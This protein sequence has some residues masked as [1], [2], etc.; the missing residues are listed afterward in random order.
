MDA[1]NTR[2]K[3]KTAPANSTLAA[4]LKRFLARVPQDVEGLVEI[5]RAAETSNLIDGDVL[6]MMEGALAVSQ[7]RVHEII[8]PRVHMVSVKCN[9]RLQQIL[10]T[11]TES[12]HSRFP[13][14]DEENHE[15]IG[16]LLAK[17][18]LA[19]ADPERAADFRIKDVLRP[20]NFVP[21][22][23]RLNVLLREFRQNHNHMAIVIDEY[24][25]ATGL[26]TIEDILEEII[27]EIADEYD[28]EEE[29]PNIRPYRS[30]LQDG[31]KAYAVKA[32]TPMEEFRACFSA[33]AAPPGEEEHAEEYDTVGGMIVK[34]IGHVPKRG[35]SV[36][37]NGLVFTVIKADKRRI[38]LLR[39]VKDSAG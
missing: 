24:S 1:S 22:S 11:V 2:D 15:I 21:E 36:A 35:E 31:Q 16:I 27:G 4:G 9:S 37:C 13:V 29:D 38:H 18:L 20:A 17:D 3:D 6:Y 23:K 12:G 5:L 8:V 30:L 26:V 32:I 14:F 33:S 19:Y 28:Y 25:T 10:K 34:T 39:V 7:T